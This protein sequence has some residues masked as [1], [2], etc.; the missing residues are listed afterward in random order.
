MRK[1]DN[2]LKIRKEEQKLTTEQ[3]LDYHDSKSV[4]AK[5]LAGEDLDLVHDSNAKTAY[6]DLQARR[7]CIPMWNNMTASVY[8]LFLAHEVS[9]ALNTPLEGYHGNG[10]YPVGFRSF[11]NVTED[12]RIERLIIKKYPG[13]R[14]VF[15]RAYGTLFADDFFGLGDRPVGD[16][17]FIDRLNLHTKLNSMHDQI[18]I[19]FNDIE[20]G[21]VDR[22]QT[23]DTFEEIL[24]ITKEIY[25]YCKEEQEQK[26]EEQVDDYEISSD[27]NDENEQ[28]SDDEQDSITQDGDGDDSEE[29]Q[30]SYEDQFSTEEDDGS[31]EESESYIEEVEPS[32]EYGE[33]V[34]CETYENQER[35]MDQFSSDGSDLN[36]YNVEYNQSVFENDNPNIKHL[37]LKD[38]YKNAYSEYTKLSTED[39]NDMGIEWIKQDQIALEWFKGSNLKFYNRFLKENNSA[40]N[41]MVQ[42]FMRKKS[43]SNYYR[44]TESKT[45]VLNM[46]KLHGYKYNEDLF[47]K[48]VNN[49]DGDNYGMVF[50]LDQS[51]SMCNNSYV[52]LLEQLLILVEFCRRVQMPYKVYSF[53]SSTRYS[54]PRPT[55]EE[56]K[57]Y[58]T[59]KGLLNK[60]LISDSSRDGTLILEWLSSE[61]KSNDHKKLSNFMIGGLLSSVNRYCYGNK[62]DLGQFYFG[63][64]AR[65]YELKPNNTS[66]KFMMNILSLFEFGGTPLNDSLCFLRGQIFDFKQKSNAEKVTLV[67]LTDGSN[68]GPVRAKK[69]TINENGG[70]YSEDVVSGCSWEKTNKINLKI[71]GKTY[72][73]DNRRF[74][75]HTQDEFLKVLFDIDWIN[76]IK[77]NW[78]HKSYT[79]GSFQKGVTN[80]LNLTRDLTQNEKK[81][82]CIMIEDDLIL[83]RTMYDKEILVFGIKDKELDVELDTSKKV[84]KS[85]LGKVLNSM[86][87]ESNRKKMLANSYIDT[88]TL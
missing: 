35:S 85:S 40:I 78:V 81:F 18:K 17:L 49:F 28:S 42:G 26:Q 12:S 60:N 24:D 61:D 48:V 9:H 21:F 66:A 88:I 68:T 29:D 52:D 30:E 54:N 80:L 70:F 33:E 36:I 82:R 13:L 23:C 62:R 37:R 67:T 56:L 53:Y 55:D 1:G 50:L 63:S 3:L 34:V 87:I 11:L 69:N 86:N 5:I 59:N 20:Q 14:A 51:G 43:A 27:D 76:C 7:V 19:E 8:D 22:L 6:I 47:K 44:N 2:M 64:Y 31:G 58:Y 4:L 74:E 57:N 15:S 83:S 84:T 41:T 46:S 65:F 77:I 25:D 79:T 16:R 73:I 39:V 10:E 32:D 72:K 45:G 38:Y 71:D 75:G